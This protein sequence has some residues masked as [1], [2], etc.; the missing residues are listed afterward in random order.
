MI[1]IYNNFIIYNFDLIDFKETHY[2]YLLHPEYTI[3][4][5]KNPIWYFVNF[6]ASYSCF[7]E[8]FQFFCKLLIN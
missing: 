6:L 2:Y 3:L 1:I 7:A 4:V 8:S 5:W